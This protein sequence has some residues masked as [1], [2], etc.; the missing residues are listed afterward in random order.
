MGWGFNRYSRRILWLKV[1]NNPAL[2]AHHYISIVEELK[3]LC[4]VGIEYILLFKLG[5][6]YILRCDMGSENAHIAF[7]Q[8]F[9][10]RN[11]SD[12]FAG[13]HSFRYGKSVSN[14][15]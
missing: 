2:I 13:E 3:G 12:C 6:P 7:L 10:R 5:A 1:N 8:P 11:V 9:L 4:V 14:Q 15:V